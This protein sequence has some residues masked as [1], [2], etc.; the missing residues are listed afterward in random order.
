MAEEKCEKAAD[1]VGYGLTPS[2]TR[3]RWVGS[4]MLKNVVIGVLAATVA[5]ETLALCDL[6]TP[7]APATLAK[8]IAYSDFIHETDAGRV[9]SVSIKGPG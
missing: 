2:L 9:S 5:L 3:Q 4:T 1:I 7:S 6:S 8:H